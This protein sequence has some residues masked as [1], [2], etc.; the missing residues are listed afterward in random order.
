MSPDL[1]RASVIVPTLNEAAHIERLLHGL[2]AQAPDA[3][4]EII[5][6]DGGSTDGTREI[7]EQVARRQPRVRLL[8]NPAR[9]QAV[10]INLA[11]R[12]ASP[13]SDILIRVDAHAAY[14]FD[15]IDRLLTDLNAQNADSVVV[16]L[17]TV[18]AG[19]FGKGVAAVCNDFLG[20]GGAAHRMGGESR[21]V[22]HGH[23]AA[24]RRGAFEA[25]G[26]YDESFRTNE[27]AEFDVRLNARNGRIWF[28]SDIVVEYHPRET[29][30]AL[31][32][33]Y[34]RYGG[35]RAANVLKHRGGLKPRQGAPLLLLA[36]VAGA[37]LV[38][39]WRPAALLAPGMY[40]AAIA[41][42]AAY[43]A[44]EARSLCVLGAAVAAP[45]MHLSWAVGF[46]V[47]VLGPALRGPSSG[48]RALKYETEG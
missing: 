9:I 18:G 30:A 4:T 23:H 39:P 40:W 28:A 27:D 41:A 35:G 11:A 20:T 16:R 3:I 25:V 24:F 8:H 48:A 43:K 45:V 42:V 10:G 17:W 29:V 21:F 19:C 14:P 32:T 2:L 22:D 37:L 33:Q 47:R 34:F 13:E 31:A 15:F 26:G 38:A 1:P 46:L 12:A 44:V 5:V 36:G 7:V 6:A